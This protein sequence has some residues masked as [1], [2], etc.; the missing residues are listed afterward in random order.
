MPQMPQKS[1]WEE[2]LCD[3]TTTLP[4]CCQPKGAAARLYKPKFQHF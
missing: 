2:S 3:V 1:L 4:G